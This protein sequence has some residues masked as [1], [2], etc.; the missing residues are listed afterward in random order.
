MEEIVRV[1]Y[2]QD[3]VFFPE[4]IQGIKDGLCLV[5]ERFLRHQNI[6][7]GI[8]KPKVFAIAVV[9]HD[10]DVEIRIRLLTDGVDNGVNEMR[11]PVHGDYQSEP[12]V[13]L[14]WRAAIFLEGGPW[15]AGGGSKSG[16]IN[17]EE[18]KRLYEPAGRQNLDEIGKEM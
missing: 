12:E 16:E 8:G 3:L 7:P 5:I 2:D 9:G 10:V 4:S 13:F 14:P 18:R 1:E 11:F 6:D 17:E 15:S